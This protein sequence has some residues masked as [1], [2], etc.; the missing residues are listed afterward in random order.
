MKNVVAL[1]RAVMVVALFVLALVLSPQ[2]ARAEEPQGTPTVNDVAGDLYCPLCSGLTV[3]V[4]ELEVCA[5]MREV[6]AQRLAAG[7]S[8][9]QIQAYFIEQ[10]GQKVVAQPARS[11]FDLLAWVI[12]FAVMGGALLMAIAW[13]RSRERSG[14]RPLSMAPAAA[15]DDYS[16]R[17]E[18]DLQR[19]DE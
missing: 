1:L 11:G 19:L 16:A 18:R 6:I 10:Y 3:D 12:P 5:D 13:L 9:E 4:C 8:P 7:E 2:T 14:S 15:T 17:L